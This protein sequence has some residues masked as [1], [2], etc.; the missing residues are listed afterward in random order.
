MRWI[1]DFLSIKERAEKNWKALENLRQ[2]LIQIGM[3]TCGKAAG[4]DEVYTSAKKTLNQMNLLGRVMQVGCIGTC[5]LEPM[6]AVRK[7]GGP[8]IYYGNLTAKKTEEILLSYLKEDNPKSEWAVCFS[9][10]GPVDG[11]SSS[12]RIFP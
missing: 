2:P 6:M 3:G 10:E 5:Y 1:M 7:P 8:F 4:A 9:G 12:S 11:N